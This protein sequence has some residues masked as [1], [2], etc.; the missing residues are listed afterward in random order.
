M[1]MFGILIFLAA[2]IAAGLCIASLTGD[3]DDNH[4][5]HSHH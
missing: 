3:S 5:G 2:S 1:V 4:H